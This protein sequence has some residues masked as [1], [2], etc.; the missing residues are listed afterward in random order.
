[1]CVLFVLSLLFLSLVAIAT[2]VDAFR[3]RS[4][5]LVVFVPLI[6]SAGS[7]VYMS[8]VSVL[9]YPVE[10]KWDQLPDKIT[11]IYF[12]VEKQESISLWIFDEDDTRLVKLPYIETGENALEKERGKMGQGIPVTFTA[13]KSGQEGRQGGGDANGAPG[14]GIPGQERQSGET[15]EDGMSSGWKYRVES[16]GDPIPS[17]ALPCK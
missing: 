12:K 5:I 17:G 9:G 4:M 7:F 14:D 2:F 15:G 8:Y 11:V 3:K 16:Y 6:A 13:D 10:M 1:M